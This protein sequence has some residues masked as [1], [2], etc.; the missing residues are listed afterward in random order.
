[1]SGVDERHPGVWEVRVFYDSLS[2]FMQ[3]A[4][5]HYLVAAVSCEHACAVAELRACREISGTNI[6][7][8]AAPVVALHTVHEFR[9]A[10]RNGL[11]WLRIMADV[12]VL[13]LGGCDVHAG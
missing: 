13:A 2:N 12:A 6:R 1:M 11:G 7:A 5:T 10:D 8:M 9:Q 3:E 4:M